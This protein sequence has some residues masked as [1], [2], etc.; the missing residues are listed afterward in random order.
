MTFEANYFG[1]HSAVYI[2]HS[3]QFVRSCRMTN[4][5]GATSSCR[6]FS[7]TSERGEFAISRA[8]S[9]RTTSSVVPDCEYCS[10]K[11]EGMSARYK[12]WVERV[13]E[14]EGSYENVA[15]PD[16]LGDFGT[17]EEAQRLVLGLLLSIG[18]SPEDSHQIPS[19]YRASRSA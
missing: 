7:V 17:E 6:M 2:R 1:R 19:W 4:C 8:P 14:D 16:C 13:D 18:S 10:H 9:R 5:N 12:V 11:G 3:T 15:L